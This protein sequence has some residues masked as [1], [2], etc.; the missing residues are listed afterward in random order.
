MSSGAKFKDKI[1]TQQ[2]KS[3]LNDLK[4]M[5]IIFGPKLSGLYS[6]PFFRNYGKEGYP[7]GAAP[8]SFRF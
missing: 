5:K 8:K 4:N 3:F 6:S 1:F 2:C 7:T